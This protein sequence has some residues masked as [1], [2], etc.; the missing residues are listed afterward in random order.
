[1]YRFLVFTPLKYKIFSNDVRKVYRP[2][3]VKITLVVPYLILDNHLVI[4]LFFTSF[5]F[6][7]H[8][9]I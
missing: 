6:F 1:M 2:K 9:C 3:I 7:S 5:W 4:Y 8:V